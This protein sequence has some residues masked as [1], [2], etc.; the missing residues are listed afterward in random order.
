MTHYSYTRNGVPVSAAEAL[1][2]DCLRDGFGLNT[3]GVM[4]RDGVSRDGVRIRRETRDPQGRLMSTS[5]AIMEEVDDDEEAML[6]DRASLLVTDG[7]GGTA[8][9]H[10]PGPRLSMDA[11]TVARRRSVEKAYADAAAADQSAWRHPR[12]WGGA[13][14]VSA[15]PLDQMTRD[16]LELLDERERA[17]AEAAIADENAWRNAR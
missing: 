9:L 12:P 7:F 8:G 3:G 16:R 5:E 10:R 13:A 2:G 6:T 17:Y 11:E 1:D 4:F 15:V 14:A